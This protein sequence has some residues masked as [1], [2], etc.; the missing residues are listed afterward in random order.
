MISSAII[1]GADAATNIYI[2]ASGSMSGFGAYM[3]AVLAV[4]AVDAVLIIRRIK[5]NDK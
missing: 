5:K 3:C 2:A 1:G 4:A